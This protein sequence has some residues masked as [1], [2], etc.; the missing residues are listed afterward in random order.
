MTDTLLVGQVDAGDLMG[1][2]VDAVF[3]VD[4]QRSD[5]QAFALK[6]LWHF[7]KPALEADIGLG[8]GD[9]TD[10]LVSVVLQFWQAG[11]AWS[12]VLGR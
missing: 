11:P 9:G 8:G 3:A 5:S 1:A 6:R 7:P 10:D 2:E 12:E 4:R